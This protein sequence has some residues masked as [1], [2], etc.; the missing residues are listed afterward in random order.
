[1]YTYDEVMTFVEEEDVKFIRLAF[2]DFDGNMKNISIMP[3]ELG[4]AFKYGVSFDAS[5]I[6]GYGG[7]YR[8]DL[9]LFPDPSTLSILPWRPSHGRVVRM[10]C[11]I[12]YPDGRQ[13]EKDVRYI[14]KKAVA[15]AKEKGFT[16]NF[17]SEI[18]F[19]LFG[20]DENGKSTGVPFDDGGYM[21]IAPEDKGE[22]VRRE[23]CFSLLNMGITPESS[24]HEEGPGQ[25]EIDFRY[26]D[27][28]TAADNAVTFKSVVKTIATRNGL[29]ADFSPKPLADKSGNGMHIN[30][31]VNSSD[32]DAPKYFLAGVLRHIKEISRF[33]NPTEESYK[34]LGKNKA[35]RYITWSEQNRSSLIRVPA[36]QGAFRRIELRSPDP[37]ANPYIA[38]ALLIYAGLD[39]IENRI[40]PDSHTELNLYTANEDEVKKFDRLPFTLKEASDIAK[41]SRF[42]LQHLPQSYIDL[43]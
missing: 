11:D 25:N 12:K 39:G 20:T 7:E 28:L 19:Y 26:S 24:H 18:E 35:P 34:R 29:Y 41:S 31:S 10:L 21:D 17:G 27:P 4:R 37:A 13:Y 38:Y 32:K 30:I 5:A 36:A 1:M 40:E 42:I 3:D 43:F 33:L 2:C 15:C 8:S 9:F 6:K 14:L 16:F 22:N 23:I